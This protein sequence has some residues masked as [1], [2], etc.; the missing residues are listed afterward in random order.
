[1]SNTTLQT[2][3][4]NALCSVFFSCIIS[5]I[6]IYTVQSRTIFLCVLCFSR[7]LCVWLR[8]SACP[9]Y[10]ICLCAAFTWRNKD[11]YSH[12]TLS[13]LCQTCERAKRPATGPGLDPRLHS[14]LKFF[15]YSGSPKSP[16]N[17]VHGCMTSCI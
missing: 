15:K 2:S 7:F 3:C 11:I 1:M 9:F 8:V 16:F 5:V 4:G 6:V 12:N 17:R 10:V 14:E 13:R